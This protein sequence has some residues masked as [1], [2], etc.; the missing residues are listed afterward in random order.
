MSVKKVYIGST[1]E[2]TDEVMNFMTNW[3]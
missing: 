3:W 2:P 1:D